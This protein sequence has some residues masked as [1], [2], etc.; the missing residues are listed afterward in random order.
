MTQDRFDMGS[1]IHIRMLMAQGKEIP[2]PIDICQAGI[3]TK[4]TLLLLLKITLTLPLLLK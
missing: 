3:D 2:R 4:L 1:T